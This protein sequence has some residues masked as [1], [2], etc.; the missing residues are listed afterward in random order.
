M[1]VQVVAFG[2]TRTFLSVREAYKYVIDSG[3]L[4]Y[5]ISWSNGNQD[6]RIF[7]KSKRN[8]WSD[9]EEAKIA[10]LCPA[11]ITA[12]PTEMFLINA[13]ASILTNLACSRANGEILV[14]IPYDKACSIMEAMSIVQV[15]SQD[16]FVKKWLGTPQGGNPGGQG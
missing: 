11:Y 10:K 7:G 6:Y 8:R 9:V 15:Y 2:L 3:A 16:E 5:K 14:D 1:D 4:S 12:K 13:P